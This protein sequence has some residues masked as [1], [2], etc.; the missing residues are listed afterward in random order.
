M[1]QP[2]SLPLSLSLLLYIYVHIYLVGYFLLGLYMA[3]N[4]ECFNVTGWHFFRAVT[5]VV[6]LQKAPSQDGRRHG[7]PL[8]K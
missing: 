4:K 7:K 8:K 3:W 5:V 2:I 6:I 1:Q